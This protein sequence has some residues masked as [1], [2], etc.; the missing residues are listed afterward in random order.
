MNFGSYILNKFIII[1]EAQNIT[2]KQMKHY[3]WISEGNEGLSRQYRT[4]RF[5]L[6]KRRPPQA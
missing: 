1:D 4:N 3:H 5:P 6:L 2:P